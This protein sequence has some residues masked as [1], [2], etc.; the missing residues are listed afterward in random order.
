MGLAYLCVATLQHV[1]CP[2]STRNSRHLQGSQTRVVPCNRLAKPISR[3]QRVVRAVSEEVMTN[4]S[5]ADA[6]TNGA[7]VEHDRLRGTSAATKAVHGG[8]RAGR[9]RVSGMLRCICICP[10]SAKP[11]RPGFRQFGGGAA[12][13]QSC[14][15][16]GTRRL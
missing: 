14:L 8:E 13:C 9:P 12:E 7:S 15:Q 11:V 3:Q 4:G 2:L 5:G 1:Y 16:A 6:N 10:G